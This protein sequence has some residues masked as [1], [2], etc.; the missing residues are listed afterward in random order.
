MGFIG[1]LL[2]AFIGVLGGFYT[3]SRI[4]QKS[5]KVQR[6]E[7]KKRKKYILEILKGEIQHNVQLLEQIQKEYQT[8]HWVGYY[9][10]DTTSKQAVW[11][12]LIKMEGD[13]QFIYDLSRTY[14]EYQHMNRKLDLQLS[15]APLAWKTSVCSLREVVVSSIIAHTGSLVSG[16]KDRLKEIEEKLNSLS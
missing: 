12:E 10:L 2:G 15:Y 4:M 9:N 11:Q 5:L 7:E 16:S 14:Y 1:T 3:Q 13:E 8:P 6:Q